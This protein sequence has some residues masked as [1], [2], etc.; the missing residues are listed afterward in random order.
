MVRHFRPSVLSCIFSASYGVL[1][2]RVSECMS[3]CAF[4]VMVRHFRRSVYLVVCVC[5]ALELVRLLC[6]FMDC[7]PMSNDLRFRAV[8]AV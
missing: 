3:L 6:V 5:S 8:F 4:V 1:F 2:L 7:V